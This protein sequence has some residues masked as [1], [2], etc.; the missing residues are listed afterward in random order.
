MPHPG[1][2][3]TVITFDTIEL[4]DDAIQQL[5]DRGGADDG[6]RV[7]KRSADAE[8]HACAAFRLLSRWNAPWLVW[9]AWRAA[10]RIHVGDYGEIQIYRAVIGQRR[11]AGFDKRPIAVERGHQRKA[12]QAAGELEPHS[13]NPRPAG[14]VWIGQRGI[15]DVKA[16]HP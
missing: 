2:A 3:T 9:L 16:D 7:R 5:F 1:V 4:H 14:T 12:R 10:G 15:R 11:G 13:A 6:Q 8:S